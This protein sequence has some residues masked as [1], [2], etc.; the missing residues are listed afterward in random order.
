[1]GIGDEFLPNPRGKEV[2]ERDG[3]GWVMEWI[4]ELEDSIMYFVPIVS[5]GMTDSS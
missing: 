3:R 1:M 4:G 2:M 5:R